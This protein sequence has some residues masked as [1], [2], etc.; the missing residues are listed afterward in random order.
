MGVLPVIPPPQYTTRA[1]LTER[2]PER[3]TFLHEQIL[4]RNSK[5][6]HAH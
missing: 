4:K 6:A 5:E 3:S 2:A 1:P